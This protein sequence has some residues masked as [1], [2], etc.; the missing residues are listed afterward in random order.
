MRRLTGP[1]WY[2]LCNTRSPPGRVAKL[3]SAEDEKDVWHLNPAHMVL[4]FLWG[5][6]PSASGI[7]L[8]DEA[9]T[10]NPRVSPPRPPPPT[11]LPSVVLQAQQDHDR[12]Q[13][14][15]IPKKKKSEKWSCCWVV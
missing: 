2:R 4:V 11:L 8:N 9:S 14:I 15:V 6:E 5:F 3:F 10:V 1:G 13:T 12:K 7:D